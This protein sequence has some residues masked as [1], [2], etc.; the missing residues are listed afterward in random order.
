MG[1]FNSKNENIT[2]HIEAYTAFGKKPS[3]K[4]STNYQT[5]LVPCYK[6]GRRVLRS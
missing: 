1:A 5:G 4:T 6:T 2:I 3:P